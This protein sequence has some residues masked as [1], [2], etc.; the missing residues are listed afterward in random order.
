MIRFVFLQIFF[1]KKL[2][3]FF[4]H[5]YYICAQVPEPM[6]IILA[7]RNPNT[8]EEAMNILFVSGYTNY[9]YHDGNFGSRSIYTTHMND[10]RGNHEGARSNQCNQRFISNINGNF[11]ENNCYNGNKQ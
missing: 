4:L 10:K 3:F 8:L 9:D 6:G 7:C 2:K 5:L 1:S 11:V